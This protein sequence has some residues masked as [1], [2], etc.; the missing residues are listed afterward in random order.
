MENCALVQTIETKLNLFIFVR[1]VNLII[2][3]IREFGISVLVEHSR[4][5]LF[6]VWS[7]L[8]ET[9]RLKLHKPKLLKSDACSIYHVT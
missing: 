7:N 5:V 8:Y 3:Q 9:L 4:I 2:V 1:N 6:V